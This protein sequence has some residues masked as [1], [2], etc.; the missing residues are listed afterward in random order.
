MIE[1]PTQPSSVGEWTNQ[2]L[3]VATCSETPGNGEQWGL[4]LR[5]IVVAL[6]QWCSPSGFMLNPVQNTWQSSIQAEGAKKSDILCRIQ[7]LV[8]ECK[9]QDVS[10][11]FGGE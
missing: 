6:L 5:S 11:D 2:I 7:Q 1:W 9:V 10:R 3:R 8:V 4:S